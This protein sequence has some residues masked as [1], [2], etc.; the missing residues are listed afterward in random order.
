[1]PRDTAIKAEGRVVEVLPK[2]IVRVE[3]P[4]G[5]RIMAHFSGQMRMDLIRIGVGDKVK[6]LIS[7]FDL[8][9]GCVVEKIIVE[10]T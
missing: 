1:V 6:V 4:N 3:L 10:T 8:S 7:P 2:L 5:H 9:K